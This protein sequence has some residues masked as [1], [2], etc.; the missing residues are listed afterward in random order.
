[1]PASSWSSMRCGHRRIDS[2]GPASP[3]PRTFG[4]HAGRGGFGPGSRQYGG[5]RFR[6]RASHAPSP[7]PWLD[8]TVGTTTDPWNGRLRHSVTPTGRSSRPERTVSG[9]GPGWPMPLSRAS[10]SLGVWARSPGCGAARIQVSRGAPLRRTRPNGRRTG[11]RSARRRSS[12]TAAPY[13]GDVLPGAPERSRSGASAQL[14]GL[15]RGT[16]PPTRQRA[17]FASANIH[18]DRGGTCRSPRESTLALGTRRTLR[19]IC[20]TFN[21]FL[22]TP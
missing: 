6:H 22:S 1:M 4:Q 16:R 21:E 12:S 11:G 13:S 14:G 17:I 15:R 18:K 19:S 10:G 3:G 8:G 20:K 9:R 2:R 5:N 7:S